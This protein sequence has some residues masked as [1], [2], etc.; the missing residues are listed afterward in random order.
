MSIAKYRW[1]DPDTGHV[2][3][4]SFARLTELGLRRRSGV[5]ELLGTT[6]RAAWP[7]AL[8]RSAAA[9]KD[10]N[11]CLW[12]AEDLLVPPSFLQERVLTKG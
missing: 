2:E 1:K 4:I 7:E 3:L 8:F 10:P 11:E 6:V 5:L 12:R 9:A